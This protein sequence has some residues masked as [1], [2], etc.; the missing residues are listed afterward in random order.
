M[1]FPIRECHTDRLQKRPT[2]RARS[3][4]EARRRRRCPA[5]SLATTPGPQASGSSGPSRSVAADALPRAEA[6][7]VPTD[8]GEFGALDEAFETM[9]RKLVV[10]GR[11]VDLPVEERELEY[12]GLCW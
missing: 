2:S 6:R 8:C 5:S 12:E 1:A 11:R 7:L 9:A 10:D 3:R 4:R